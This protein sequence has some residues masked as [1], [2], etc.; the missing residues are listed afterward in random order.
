MLLSMGESAM[1]KRKMPMTMAVLRASFLFLTRASSSPFSVLS[2][3]PVGRVE[4][5]FLPK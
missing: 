4:R 1:V 5:M 2:P 3:Y